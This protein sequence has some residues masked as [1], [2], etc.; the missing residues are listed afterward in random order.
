MKAT[1]E[2]LE[3]NKVKLSVEVDDSEFEKA[4]DAAFRKMAHEVRIPGFRPGKAP[5][6]LLEARLGKDTARQEAL[7]EALPDYYAQAVKDADLDPIAPPEIDITSEGAEGPIAFDAVVE[8]RP[9]V[10][11]PGY[12]GLQVTVPSP[13]VT[14]EDVDR[15]IDRMRE[16]DADLRPVERAAR[17][18][19]VVTI[20]LTA[21]DSD[22]ADTSYEVGSES[23]VPGLDEQLAGA[24]VG[25]ILQFDA[26][27]QGAEEPTSIRVLVKD[28]KEK[29]LP[30]PTD[31]WAAEASEFETVAELREDTRKRLATVKRL[32][33]SLAM[34]DE[35]L[36]AL[37]QL[38]EDDVPQPLVDQEV[39]RRARDLSHRLEHQGASIVQYLQATGTTEEQ[40]V[41]QLTA[42][43]VEAVKA[44]LA[45]R[46]LAEAEQIEP[47]E[48]D[49]DEEV[50][51]LAQRFEVKPDK[52]RKDLERQ[53]A[54]PTVRSDVK[55][56]KALEWLVQ[57]V[58]V[59][60]EE[61]HPID[62]ADLSPEA[63][64]LEQEPA[65]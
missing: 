49:V 33:A 41:G 15:Q 27:A 3:G 6:K 18:G 30:E 31:E 11:I 50:A 16:R 44:D 7:R 22:L 20:D 12:G 65:E 1:V 57:H 25:D 28:V 51:R 45:L 14:D 35:S 61:G 43:A 9:L 29:V 53:E 64:P 47:T 63:E 19:D 10:A 8:V 39:E 37:V 38:V 60:D 52:L 21:G 59:V 40:F 54:I 5:R 26:T 42:D 62:R 48:E 2:P 4:L 36:K 46:A 13:H 34:R 17:S 55:K 23:L 56:A 24:K 58:E 32:Q